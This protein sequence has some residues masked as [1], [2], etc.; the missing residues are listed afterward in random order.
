M[1]Q[2]SVLEHQIWVIVCVHAACVN[3]VVGSCLIESP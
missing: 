1:F 3:V 2:L